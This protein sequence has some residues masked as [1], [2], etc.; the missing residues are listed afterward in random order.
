MTALEQ[1]A[2]RGQQNRPW[3]GDRGA[4]IAMSVVLTEGLPEAHPFALNLAVSLAVL[5][6]I[7]STFHPSNGANWTSNGQRH[8]AG[9]RQSR[10]HPH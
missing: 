2:G 7:E 10:G 9:R 3:H 8:H 5:E 4:D 1:T 6:G